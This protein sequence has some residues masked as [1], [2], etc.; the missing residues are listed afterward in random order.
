M[1]AFDA[2]LDKWRTH[3]PEM[4]V[5]EAFCARAERARFR[6]WGVLLHELLESAY[7]PSE[8]AVA[9]ARLAWWAE[10]LDARRGRHPVSATVLESGA[11]AVPVAPVALAA[12]QLVGAGRAP[13]TL[14]D[15]LQDMQ[16]MAAA[17]ARAEEAMFGGSAAA[18]QVQ[19]AASL[20]VRAALEACAGRALARDR[21]PMDL[22]ARWPLTA[23]GDAGGLRRELA[24]QLLAV[25]G[26]AG[27]GEVLFRRARSGFDRWRLGRWR[28]GAP[29]QNVPA[30]RALWIARRAAR[31]AARP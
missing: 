18:E 20:I 14:A 6:L 8:P 29:G 2:F 30:L 28:S 9:Q 5:A 21:M 1:Q 3:E 27:S 24:V 19:I 16:S 25:V 23:A 11:G 31:G 15:A 4:E 12:Q 13:R 7:A 17:I 10:E 22:L 26:A